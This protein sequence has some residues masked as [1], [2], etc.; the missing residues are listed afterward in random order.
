[1]KQKHQ[2]EEP[3]ESLLCSSWESK[4]VWHNKVF[5]P[6]FCLLLSKTGLKKEKKNKGS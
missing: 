6:L 2:Q 5:G 4:H 3:T 1:M